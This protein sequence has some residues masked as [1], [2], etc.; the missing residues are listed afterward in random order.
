MRLEGPGSL[1]KG[2]RIVV[3]TPD[4]RE[5]GGV[6]AEIRE[7][8]GGRRQVVVRLDTGWL[9]TYPVE[10]VHDAETPGEAERE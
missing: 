7:S 8:P 2:R 3:R 4:R 6:V 10:M 5:F 1:V 9:T